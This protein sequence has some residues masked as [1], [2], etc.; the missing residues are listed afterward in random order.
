MSKL[1]SCFVAYGSSIPGQGD[2]IENAVEKIAAG[3]LIDIKSW[4]DLQIA[5]HLIAQEVCDVIYASDL[6]IADVTSLNPNVLFE[7]G[8]AISLKKRIWL[9]HDPSLKP[10]TTDFDLFQI[11][12]TIGC[13]KYSNSFEIE[14]QFYQDR[15]YEGSH[16]A[17]YEQLIRTAGPNPERPPVLYVKPEV[18]TEA[19]STLTRIMTSWPLPHLIDDPNEI[20]VQSL[21]WYVQRVT[22]AYAVVCHFLSDQHE[23]SK[24][25]HAKNSLVAGLAFGLGKPLLMLAH[26]P[27]KSP[28]DY[29]DVL[30]VHRNASEARSL[31]D[32]W[33]KPLLESYEE[34]SRATLIYKKM[35]TAKEQL[36][37]IRIGDPIAEY[38]ADSILDYFVK[39]AAYIDA[40]QSQYSIFVGRKGTGKT[41]TLLKIAEEI[42][43]DPRNHVC[44]IRP[45]EY[46]LEGITSMLK[47]EISDSER[48][49]LVESFWK[50]LVYTELAKSFYEELLRKPTY[51]VRTSAEQSLFAFVENNKSYILLEF[52]ARLE[53]VVLGLKHIYIEVPSAR[54]NRI[55]ELLH[56]SMLNQLRS[57]LGAA[58]SKNHKVAILIDNLDKTWTVNADLPS[59]SELL[60]G[61][62]GVGVRISEEFKRDASKL[63]SIDIMMA[64]FMRS[65]IFEAISKSARERDKLPLKTVQWNDPELLRRVIE[66][67]FVKS[68]PEFGEDG[69][70]WRKYFDPTVSGI[71]TKE[72]LTSAVFPRP[73]DLLVLTKASLQFA[74]NRGHMKISEPDVLS[75]LDQYSSFAYASL[76][77]E[78]VPR[79]PRFEEMMMTILGGSAILEKSALLVAASNAQP[80]QDPQEL[81]TLLGE[82]G[83]LGYEVEPNRFEYISRPSESVKISARAAKIA[84]SDGGQ[85]YQVHPIFQRYLEL[86][87]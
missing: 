58:L 82:L 47:Q 70:I 29:R 38:E 18:S 5:G 20:R 49:Y 42:K 59:I 40:L 33:A 87:A 48:G 27:Y 34:T 31:F 8:Y 4:T 3:G 63:K 68:T 7:L 30:R 6:F 80:D 36:L 2:A 28:L 37:N 65:D 55:S 25:N 46:E 26:V 32:A 13:R 53:T 11:L 60:L 71:P 56:N 75:A 15:P 16:V 39:T 50:F 43:S 78:V 21:A 67:R 57:L 19:V 66:E 41:A 51:Y 69:D 85:R 61:L 72:F 77:A 83:F 52:S 73:R 45:L 54:K 64:I 23:S 44:L 79:F 14:N 17:V 10:A 81:V 12:T 74:V 86:K 1:P 24:L 35:V 76:E 62:L 22:S 9:L 84:N